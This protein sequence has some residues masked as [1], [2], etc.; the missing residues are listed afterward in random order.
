MRTGNFA[1][2]LALVAIATSV[3]AAPPQV[4][5]K[6]YGKSEFEGNCASCHGVDGK[7]SGPVTPWL[8]K[9]PPD[10]T[11]LAQK[12]GGILPLDRL[13]Q[14]VS[15]EGKTAHGTR[16]MPVWG[17]TFRTLAAEQYMDYPYDPEPIVRARI[18]AILEY[19]N[20][21]QVGHR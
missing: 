11:T 3:A 12:N 1:A 9:A 16:E 20:R 15:G 18:L 7:G 10:L 21:I 13:Y 8:T 14:S 17:Q 5:I 2:A 6:D 4:R 19:I